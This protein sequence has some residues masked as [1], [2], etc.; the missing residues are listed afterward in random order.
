MNVDF[1]GTRF[2]GDGRERLDA[3]P[4]DVLPGTS[5]LGMNRASARRVV[6]GLER[7]GNTTHSGRGGVLWVL[8]EWARVKGLKV[9]VEH[10]KGMGYVVY[11]EG[12]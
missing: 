8:L 1:T 2:D 4:R 12:P 7:F 3:D 6:E 9:R 11:K 10:P 5:P